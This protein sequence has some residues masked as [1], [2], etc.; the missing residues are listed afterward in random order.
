MRKNRCRLLHLLLRRQ[1]RVQPYLKKLSNHLQAALQ[2]SR[3]AQLLRWATFAAYPSPLG[4][5]QTPRSPRSVPPEVRIQKPMDLSKFHQWLRKPP[6]HRH[7][8]SKNLH[9]TQQQPPQT[10]RYRYKYLR[11]PRAKRGHD[12]RRPALKAATA[13]TLPARA[14]SFLPGPRPRLKGYPLPRWPAST[15]KISKSPRP[16]Q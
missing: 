13:P 3:R 14:I 11:T 2:P 5:E 10:N 7:D 15:I 1:T 16:P 12:L 8:R 4:P 6:D 9:Q